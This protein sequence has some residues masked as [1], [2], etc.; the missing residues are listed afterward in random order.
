MVPR[1]TFDSYYGRPI[2]KA[3]AWEARDIAGYFFLGGLAGAG[4]VL[5]AAHQATG[6]PRTATALKITSLGSVGLATAALIHDLGVPSRFTH[7]L[8]VIKP[9]SPMS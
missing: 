1:A 5:A 2:I 9:T 4:S 7:M 6:A 3:P 8:R